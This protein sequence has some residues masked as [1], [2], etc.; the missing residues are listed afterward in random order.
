MASGL[1]SSGGSGPDSSQKNDKTSFEDCVCPICLD[2]LIR[3]IT[4]P[5]GHELCMVCFQENV[6]ETSL[7]CPMCRLRISSWARKAARHNRLVNEKRW[8]QIQRLFPKQVEKRLEG[9]DNEDDYLAN[10]AVPLHLAQ[11]GEIRKEYEEEM[12]KLEAERVRA[13]E[14]EEQASQS[15]IQKILEEEKRQAEERKRERERLASHDEEL[16][17]QLSEKI[18]HEQLDTPQVNSLLRHISG[19]RQSTRSHSSN[20]S[21]SGTP[22]NASK[23]SK[24]HN[25][26]SSHTLDRFLTK[27]SN[28]SSGDDSKNKDKSS[29]VDAYPYACINPEDK[30]GERLLTAGDLHLN[31]DTCFSLPRSASGLSNSSTDSILTLSTASGVGSVAGQGT[32][33]GTA[34]HGAPPRRI[35]TDQEASKGMS[36]GKSPRGMGLEEGLPKSGLLENSVPEGT[37]LGDSIR[38]VKVV[39]KPEMR[40]KMDAAQKGFKGSTGLKKHGEADPGQGGSHPGRSMSESDEL[41]RE[42]AR[43]SS[44]EEGSK[45]AKRSASAQSEDSI[46]HELTHFKPIHGYPRTPPRR[47]PGG[48]VIEPS[49]IVCSPR[50]LSRAGSMGS[51]TENGDQSIMDPTSPIVKKRLQRLAEERQAQVQ[52]L[53]KATSTEI[54]SSRINKEHSYSSPTKMIDH[55]HR[56]WRHQRETSS[57]TVNMAKAEPAVEGSAVTTVATVATTT[58]RAL[59]SKR[60]A[61][62]AASSSSAAATTLAA[63]GDGKGELQTAVRAINFDLSQ[64]ES[65]VHGDNTLIDLTTSNSGSR[66]LLP[67]VTNF[68]VLHDQDNF[69]VPHGLGES[70]SILGIAN[71]SV[72]EAQETVSQRD[73]L[74][75][76]DS[77]RALHKQLG[78]QNKDKNNEHSLLK[79]DSSSMDKNHNFSVP[80]KGLQMASST[81]RPVC[82]GSPVAAQLA[83]KHRLEKFRGDGAIQQKKSPQGGSSSSSTLVKLSPGK[84]YRMNRSLANKKLEKARD[85]KLGEINDEPVSLT[86]RPLHTEKEDALSSK[87]PQTEMK[88]KSLSD[89]KASLLAASGTESSNGTKIPKVVTTPLTPRKIAQRQ[90]ALAMKQDADHVTGVAVVRK[91]VF[92]SNEEEEEEEE[93]ERHSLRSTTEKKASHERR[94]QIKI[95]S[96]LSGG[97]EDSGANDGVLSHVSLAETSLLD[98]GQTKCESSSHKELRSTHQSHRDVTSEYVSQVTKNDSNKRKTSAKEG[99]AVRSPNKQNESTPHK[100]SCR[101]RDKATA[102]EASPK[103]KASSSSSRKTSSRKRPAA[104]EVTP[105]KKTSET[106]PNKIGQC[107]RNLRCKPQ[108][109]RKVSMRLQTQETTPTKPDASDVS[110]PVAADVP[111]FRNLRKRGKFLSDNFSESEADHVED[112]EDQHIAAPNM[113]SLRSRNV[114]STPSKTDA[115]STHSDTENGEDHPLVPPSMRSARSRQQEVTPGR[116]KIT[117]R[118][119]TSAEMSPSKL[120]RTTLGSESTSTGKGDADFQSKT[121]TNSRIERSDAEKTPKSRTV[122][123]R[124]KSDSI[125]PFSSQSK[126]RSRG[127][128]VTPSKREGSPLKDEAKLSFAKRL[129]KSSS[130]EVTNSKDAFSGRTLKHNTKT[131]S[132]SDYHSSTDSEISFPKS[133]SKKNSSHSNKRKETM[134]RKGKQSDSTQS[135]LMF[136]SEQVETSTDDDFVTP[137]KKRKLVF[138]LTKGTEV[139]SKRLTSQTKRNRRV[140]KNRALRSVDKDNP[141]ESSSSTPIQPYTQKL[142]HGSKAVNSKSKLTSHSESQQWGMKGKGEEG[143]LIEEDEYESDEVG[144]ATTVEDDD[145]TFALKLQKQFE[146]EARLNTTFHRSH[147]SGDEYK[148]RE[149]RKGSTPVFSPVSTHTRSND[150]KSRV[151]KKPV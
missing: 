105:S 51:P 124:G 72:V 50:N 23:S 6:Q 96:E 109:D 141:H 75:N 140:Q 135:K 77:K 47:L 35:K 24:K 134:K 16:A 111:P 93:D 60:D 131:D 44:G 36:V 104:R 68:D 83:G 21:R 1:K 62:C 82:P 52:A 58:L 19:S 41:L 38:I 43:A 7:T 130:V 29:N 106:S 81:L 46:S 108:S 116:S 18:Q 150:R 37:G 117:S 25:K 103:N 94:H 113:R 28:K 32:P 27:G 123:Q 63:S 120:K 79:Q 34:G 100:K 67:L 26:N 39:V 12:K 15:I 110:R 125:K 76:V 97:G 14:E 87:N 57:E 53:S 99:S 48:K 138:G 42:M 20:S 3:P 119:K 9:E 84:V 30:P 65:L 151:R 127:G 70:G 73:P 144:T 142:R 66:T 146:Y 126:M 149:R 80:Q 132:E 115:A 136:I 114:D 33:R 92:G 98:S 147:G 86:R 121:D 91:R 137:N 118:T 40:K 139:A 143:M 64:Q 148:F 78:G 90:R 85:L 69:I 71:D 11:P 74:T 101:D 8:R 45:G 13:A 88:I 122:S 145:F 2:I 31:L 54:S 4:M 133:A 17:K 107:D 5:C 61:P 112:E 59:C 56:K 55:R 10:T 95:S 49:V 102:E 22:K 129:R 128:E 89:Q